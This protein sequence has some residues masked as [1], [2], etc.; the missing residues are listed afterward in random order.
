VG[1]NL[2]QLNWQGK[3]QIE[4]RPGSTN[5]KSVEHMRFITSRAEEGIMLEDSELMA[6]RCFE[7]SCRFFMENPRV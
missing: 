3:L 6:K 4:C 7:S 2:K 1:G 5:E